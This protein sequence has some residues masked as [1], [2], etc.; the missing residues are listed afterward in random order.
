MEIAEPN[1][2][3][4][5]LLKYRNDLSQVDWFSK[6]NINQVFA[7]T[8]S[9]SFNC[10]GIGKQSYTQTC[11]KSKCFQYCTSF[12]NLFLLF[13][14]PP[15]NGRGVDVTPFRHFVLPDSVSDHFLCHTLRFSNE[16]WYMGLSR[17]YAGWVRIWVRSN[18]FW[19]SYAP[20]T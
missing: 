19:Q 3:T 5:F 15:W 10:G 9:P 6:L 14:P 13:M 16:I 8:V 17:E 1:K 2:F 18:N 4:N 12:V 7:R 20:W 11:R